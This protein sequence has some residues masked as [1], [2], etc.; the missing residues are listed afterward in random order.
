MDLPKNR[1]ADLEVFMSARDAVE[2]A[3]LLTLM[4]KSAL[5]PEIVKTPTGG[6][7]FTGGAASAIGSNLERTVGSQSRGTYGIW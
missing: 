2:R 7:A 3:K 6:T 1:Q 5:Q 4:K